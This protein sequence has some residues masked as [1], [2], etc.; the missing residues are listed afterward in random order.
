MSRYLYRPC[1]RSRHFR[2]TWIYFHSWQI[3]RI[4]LYKH[5]STPTCTLSLC[6][7][8]M[9]C[10]KSMRGCYNFPYRTV[11]IWSVRERGVHRLS[12]YVNE[13]VIESNAADRDGSTTSLHRR[14]ALATQQQQCSRQSRPDNDSFTKVTW[15]S[16]CVIQF[17]TRLTA[18]RSIERQLSWDN[19]I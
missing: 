8:T 4:G 3:C 12:A 1:R 7:S 14:R 17:R 2:R 15:P 19:C 10:G 16:L 11:K 18:C 5:T 13:L 6:R 9:I